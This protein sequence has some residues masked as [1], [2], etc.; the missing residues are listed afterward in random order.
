MTEN[1]YLELKTEIPKKTF[2]NLSDLKHQLDDKFS[3]AEIR[4]VLNELSEN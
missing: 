4:L 1:H 2:E 3:Y